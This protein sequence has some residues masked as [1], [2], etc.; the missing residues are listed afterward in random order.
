MTFAR[1]LRG[2]GAISAKTLYVDA[3]RCHKRAL[4]SPLTHTAETWAQTLAASPSS[5]VPS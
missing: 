5:A 2:L 4:S 1:E 3:A